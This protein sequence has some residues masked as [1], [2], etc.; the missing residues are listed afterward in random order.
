MNVIKAIREKLITNPL[1]N[2]RETLSDIYNIVY[3][4]TN[5]YETDFEREIIEGGYKYT[6]TTVS[7]D[8][9]I[10]IYT[11]DIF[12]KEDLTY[13]KMNYDNVNIQM[14]WLNDERVT[15]FEYV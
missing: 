12:R 8:N 1:L 14:I 11:F 2:E 13:F 6:V 3:S 9:H 4:V 7:H 15:I 10:V 5:M